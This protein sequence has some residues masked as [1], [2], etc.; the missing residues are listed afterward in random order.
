MK[1]E[2]LQYIQ[3]TS[4]GYDWKSVFTLVVHLPE[5]CMS[6]LQKVFLN[7]TVIEPFGMKYLGKKL[8]N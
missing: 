1:Q 5:I 2:D 6:G 3:L 4:C 8:F 7:I